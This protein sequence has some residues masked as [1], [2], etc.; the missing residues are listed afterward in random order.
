MLPRP[1][2]S[3]E[4]YSPPY[5]FLAGSVKI[6]QPPSAVAFGSNFNVEFKTQGDGS[7]FIDRVVLLR[8]GSV[9]HHFDST[10]RYIELAFTVA[11]GNTLV[12]TAPAATLTPKGYYRLYAVMNDNGSRIPSQGKFLR[13][14]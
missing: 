5:M 2:Y 9:T 3:F 13:L 6:G 7:Q 11:E 1:E 4:L 10:Q 14:F 12:I 8:P